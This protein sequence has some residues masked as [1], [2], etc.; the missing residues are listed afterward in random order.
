MEADLAPKHKFLIWDNRQYSKFAAMTVFSFCFF[1]YY[2]CQVTLLIMS[3][4]F[5]FGVFP[6]S[7][8]IPFM[9]GVKAACNSLAFYLGTT[10]FSLYQN[11]QIISGPYPAFCAMSGQSSQGISLTIFLLVLRIE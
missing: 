5:S 7:I 8:G 2:G 10:D 11:I 1:P 6:K 9:F 4:Y 3:P